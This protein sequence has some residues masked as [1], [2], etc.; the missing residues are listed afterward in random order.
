M[1]VLSVFQTIIIILSKIGSV[2]E[3]PITSWVLTCVWGGGG[4]GTEITITMLGGGGG[5]IQ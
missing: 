2:R 5:G 4:G 1:P 3:A